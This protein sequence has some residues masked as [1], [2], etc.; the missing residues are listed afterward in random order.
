[1]ARL[2]ACRHPALYQQLSEVSSTG[3]MAHV[4][5]RVSSHGAVF[6]SFLVHMPPQDHELLKG[7]HL[8]ALFNMTSLVCSTGQGMWR[9]LKNLLST[10]KGVNE[11]TEGW[12][13]VT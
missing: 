10:T 7:K 2:C 13:E 6:A 11:W 1:M 12:M 3:P 8:F 9:V 4:P 5:P